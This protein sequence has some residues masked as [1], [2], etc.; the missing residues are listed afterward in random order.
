MWVLADVV[1]LFSIKVGPFSPNVGRDYWIFSAN[2]GLKRR[3]LS[4]QTVYVLWPLHIP[5][6]RPAAIDRAASAPC[7]IVGCVTPCMIRLRYDLKD[8]TTVPDQNYRNQS[9]AICAVRNVEPR[10]YRAN[11][12]ARNA[13]ARFQFAVRNVAPRLQPTPSFALIAAPRLPLSRGRALIR[14]QSH[15]RPRKRF[16]SHLNMLMLRPRSTASARR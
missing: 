7:S 9:G 16:A 15:P 4:G 11:G 6:C 2:L 8:G 5:A 10:A 3:M 1:G 12:S 14:L 13:V